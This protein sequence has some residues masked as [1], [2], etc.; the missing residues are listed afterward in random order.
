V[1]SKSSDAPKPWAVF[2]GA[3][4][5]PGAPEDQFLQLS[6][7][8]RTGWP[9]HVASV[10]HAVIGSRWRTTVPLRLADPR[11]YRGWY[12]VLTLVPPALGETASEHWISPGTTL[13]LVKTRDDHLDPDKVAFA[14]EDAATFYLHFGFWAYCEYRIE[15]GAWAGVT[16]TQLVV[17]GENQP[18]SSQ[19]AHATL[20]PLS[21]TRQR[22]PRD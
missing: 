21:P 14:E 10:E 11:G 17:D 12:H 22:Q 6:F 1:K 15:T 18:M 2:P 7:D 19:I 16:V 5:P 8:W 20:E 13:T 3:T 4:Q 9:P